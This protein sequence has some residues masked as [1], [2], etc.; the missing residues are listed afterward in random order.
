M[1]TLAQTCST[2]TFEKKQLPWHFL[3]FRVV[4]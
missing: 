2:E 3:K 4:A 1:K